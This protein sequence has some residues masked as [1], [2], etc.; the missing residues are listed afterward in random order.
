MLD[1]VE[2]ALRCQRLLN[3]PRQR[4]NISAARQLPGRIIFQRF[5]C[6][7]QLPCP[8]LAHAEFKDC[9][10]SISHAPG[11]QLGLCDPFHRLT[12]LNALSETYDTRRH[13][14]REPASP[15]NSQ[16]AMHAYAMGAVLH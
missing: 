1:D 14:L 11:P 7:V 12:N 9:Y 16:A 5:R 10:I 8:L 6:R 3:V 4:C 15:C 2:S 13:G